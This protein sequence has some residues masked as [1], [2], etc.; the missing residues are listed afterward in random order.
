MVKAIFFDVDGTIISYE[1]GKIPQSTRNVI[2]DLRKQGILCVLATG[3]SLMEL[4]DLDIK[5]LE[6]DGYIMLNGQLCFDEHKRKLWGVPI[7]SDDFKRGL[8]MFNDKELPL[9]FVEVNR[10]Y[11]N[12]ID[13]TVEVAQAS[14]SSP[15]MDVDSYK[16]DEVYQIAVFASADKESYLKKEF[17]N[18]KVTKWNTC[19]FDVIANTG[20]KVWGIQEYCKMMNI[21]KNEI[22]AFGDG[23]NDME[24]LQYA[25]VGIAMGNANDEVKVVSDYVTDTVDKD[26][27]LKALQ[28]YKVVKG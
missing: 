13:E 6:F 10:L 3:R 14:I 11:N 17:P 1:N 12:F 22:M 7:P 8:R 16:G 19:A 23:E 26:G 4:E 20:G 15:L 25:H 9:S 18:C 28:H 27:I 2:C 5:D 21:S 24:M